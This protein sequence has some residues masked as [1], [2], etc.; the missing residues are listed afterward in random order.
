MIFQDCF[1]FEIAFFFNFYCNIFRYHEILIACFFYTKPP[2]IIVSFVFVRIPMF[3]L[4]QCASRALHIGSH[5][6]LDKL[7]E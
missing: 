2:L 7:R 1:F 4:K 6:I 3:R 5:K